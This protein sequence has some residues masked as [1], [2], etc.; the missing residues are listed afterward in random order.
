M[1]WD[2]PRYESAAPRHVTAIID[3]RRR[4]PLV[5]RLRPVRGQAAAVWS[6]QAGLVLQS[7]VP[8][9][10]ME[11]AQR[12]LRCGG[13]CTFTAQVGAHASAYPSTQVAAYVEVCFKPECDLKYLVS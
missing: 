10:R 11:A 5:L 3:A 2:N 1:I 6:V 9:G 13:G 12:R 8:E 4:H 7:R